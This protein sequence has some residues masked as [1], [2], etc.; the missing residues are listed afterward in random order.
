MIALAWILFAAVVVGVL[1]FSWAITKYYNDRHESEPLPTIVTIL[2]LSLALF[3]VFL[4]PVDIYSVSSSVDGEG[5]PLISPSDIQVRADAVRV[6]YYIL[7]ASMGAF[8]FG[9][10]PFAY[11]YYEEDDEDVTIKQRIWGGCKYTI[12]LLLIVI[13]LFVIGFFL[14]FVKPGDKPTSTANAKAWV[15]GLMDDENIGDAAMAFSTAGM[16]VI[17]Y[18]AFLIYTS[19]G[20]SSYPIGI[21]RG[22]KHVAE[23]VSEVVGELDQTRE[24]ANLLKSKYLNKPRKEWAKKDQEQMDLLTRKEKILSRHGQR[25]HA[26]HTGWRKAYEAIRPFFFIFGILF[27]GVSLLIVASILLTNIDKA[28]NSGDFCGSQCGFVLAYPKIFNPLD[29]SL[30][31]LSKYFPLDYIALASIIFYVF[32]ATMS[33]IV[34]IGVRFLWVNMYKIRPH[35]TPPQGLLLTCV[36]LMFCILVLNMEITTLAPQYATWGAQTWYNTT[37]GLSQPCSID[38]P[39]T[40]CSM[41]QIGTFVARISLRTSFFSIIFFYATWGFL[42]FYVIGFIIAVWRRKGSNVEKREDDSDSDE[43]N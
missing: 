26:Q 25:L 28:A 31:A 19:Y 27:V 14:Y 20:L 24:K 4:I 6:I 40:A 15:T 3:S 29:T 43:G 9:V 1:A 42:V 21:I 34:N 41:T 2:G 17:G 11:F 38:A 8:I 36:L 12:F 16:T 30:T 35:S 33:G 22:K 10:I 37:S 23:E 7:Y 5:K 39:P 18:V 13:V 32:F